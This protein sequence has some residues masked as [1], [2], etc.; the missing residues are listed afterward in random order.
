MRLRR[1][2]APLER[3]RSRRSTCPPVQMGLLTKLNLL[4]VGLIF[5]TAIATTGLYSGR[6]GASTRAELR[7]QGSTLAR[8]A[9]RSLR[10]RA[11]DGRSRVPAGHSS[12][13]SRSRATSPTSRVLDAQQRTFAERTFAESLQDVARARSAP[14]AAAGDRRTIAL[15]ERDDRRAGATSSSS[16]PVGERR[17]PTAPARRRQAATA[18]LR[19]SR[20]G[21]RSDRLRAARHD[22]RAAE[23]R[24]Q[25][26]AD[27]R[28]VGRRPARRAGDRRDAAA[29]A[30]SR[31]ADAP[32][33]ARRARR[34]LRQARRLRAGELGRRARACSRTRSTT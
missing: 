4:T 31:R 15:V 9:G 2:L 6:S 34:R 18:G 30:P 13:A 22:V 27:R 21:D 7:T 10:A 12:T 23:R 25:R 24:V 26:D 16:T 5:L 3:T 29:H 11:L 8:D 1:R 28:A 17:R 32:A 19:S 14:R 20:V 33:D